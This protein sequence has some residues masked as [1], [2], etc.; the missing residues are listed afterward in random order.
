MS[1]DYPDFVARFYDAVYARVR[2]DADARYYVDRMV[3]AP[4]PALEI[5][6]GTGRV[7]L[8]AL[9]RGADAYGIDLSPSMLARL[10]DK[11][12]PSEHHR[13]WLGDAGTFQDDRR[14]ALVVAPFRVLGHVLAIDD[15]LRL[16]DNVAEHLLPGGRLIFDLYV[17][18]PRILADGIHEVL[19]F[20]GEHAPG[21]R[22]RRTVS[23]RSDVV[24]QLTH[25]TMTFAWQDDGAEIR[26]DWTF[27]LRFYFRYELEH[28]VAR[29]RLRLESIHGDFDGSPLGP[30]SREL[31][32]TCRRPE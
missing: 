26:R 4:G 1:G 32:V 14:F 23:A 6:V 7:L 21:Q 25:G 16:L 17:P 15:Q 12:P 19:D 24:N 27:T 3:E 29:S 28:L 18:S 13:V 11:L 20:D 5:G 30:E 2:D 31:V 10:R 9:E 8:P 22:L